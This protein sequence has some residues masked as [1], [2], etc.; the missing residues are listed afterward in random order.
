[1]L[2]LRSSQTCSPY[3][4]TRLTRDC[5]VD[6]LCWRIDPDIDARHFSREPR[7]EPSTAENL[8][9]KICIAACEHMRRIN[10]ARRAI[11]SLTIGPQEIVTKLFQ[12][13]KMRRSRPIKYAQHLDI[14]A[15]CPEPLNT[16]PRMMQIFVLS[17]IP[18]AS[19]PIR[20]A[21]YS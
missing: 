19:I 13:D 16:Q 5:G 17:R 7:F 3:A 10:H 8:L 2:S 18:T 1:M 21:I 15:C 11:E 12:R 6:R 4:R 20:I 9:C 14:S